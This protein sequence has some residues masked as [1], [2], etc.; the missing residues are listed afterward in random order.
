MIKFNIK[1]LIIGIVIISIISILSSIGFSAT[2]EYLTPCSN[3]TRFD[4]TPTF[5]ICGNSAFVYTSTEWKNLTSCAPLTPNTM[6]MNTSGVNSEL[7]TLADSSQYTAEKCIQMWINPAKT[8][9]ATEG[10]C[11]FGWRYLCLGWGTSDGNVNTGNTSMGLYVYN[12]SA[13]FI[14]KLYTRAMPPNQWYAVAFHYKI[15]YVTP[16]A[17]MSFAI[18]DLWIN[19]VLQWNSTL[20][21]VYVTTA[22]KVV[23]GSGSLDEADSFIGAIDHLVIFNGG[24]NSSMIGEFAGLI[25]NTASSTVNYTIKDRDNNILTPS[26]IDENTF[27][28]VYANYSLLDVPYP[29]GNC[30]YQDS[31]MSNIYTL[32]SGN[33]TFMNTSASQSLIMNENKTVYQDIIISRFCDIAGSNGNMQ[34]LI[35]NSPIQNISDTLI[36]RCNVGFHENIFNTTLYKN[37][38]SINITFKCTNCNVGHNVKMIVLNKY[39]DIILLKREERP[40]NAELMGYNATSKLFETDEFHSW[41][42]S[43][44]YNLSVNC[45]N[46]TNNNANIDRLYTVLNPM[47]NATLIKITDVIGIKS[48]LNGTIIEAS[49]ISILGDCSGDIITFRQMNVTYYNGTLIKSVNDEIITLENSEIN[50]NGIYNVSLLCKDDDTPVNFTLIKKYFQLNDTVSPTIYWGFPLMDNSS[51]IYKNN[52]F[53]ADIIYSDLNLYAVNLTCD[54]QLGLNVLLNNNLVGS[55][56]VYQILNDSINITLVSNITCIAIASDYHTL[57]DIEKENFKSYYYPDSKYLEFKH[58]DTVLN[59]SLQG[60]NFDKFNVEKMKDRYTFEPVNLDN[61]IKKLTYNIEC[62][63]EI[64]YI[65]HSIYNANF[66]CNQ[67]WVDFEIDGKIKKDYDIVRIN[68]NN[69]RITI[70]NIKAGDSLKTKS[71]GIINTQRSDVMLNVINF[72][73]IPVNLTNITTSTALTL[74]L[75]FII[76]LFFMLMTI[77]FINSSLELLFLPIASIMGIFYGITLIPYNYI[78]AYIFILFNIFYMIIIFF[79]SKNN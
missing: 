52:K 10:N 45:T 27:F 26:S 17:T 35:N 29:L 37:N 59:I 5:D 41:I 65:N 71:A 36:P 39:D 25:N 76:W 28:R 1:L 12:G 77:L 78:I 18:N 34:L 68:S 64:I 61:K 74:I 33:Y 66:V 75:F 60:F 57:N 69:Y 32:S 49:N 19:G 20:S 48:F 24:C 44:I 8:Q 42:T 3:G 50:L 63:D 47:P 4:G 67:I 23:F 70:D 54:S 43:G 11:I 62:N 9:V 15:T 51:T 16:P 21:N 55:T 7:Q 14:P 56:K 79:V 53:V 30:T 2:P 58:K 31:N 6:C 73:D 22:K 40:Y 13:Q 38:V 46:V 72:P